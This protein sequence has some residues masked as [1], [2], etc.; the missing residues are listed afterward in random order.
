MNLN[1]D[2]Y[3]INMLAFLLR[4]SVPIVDSSSSKVF[5]LPL[6]FPLFSFL[7]VVTSF[8]FV[9]TFCTFDIYDPA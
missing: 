2:G 3:L 5:F 9:A 1:S 4:S 7:F 6:S 8:F